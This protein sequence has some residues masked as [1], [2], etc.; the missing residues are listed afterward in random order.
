MKDRIYRSGAGRYINDLETGF[1]PNITIDYPCSQS[2]DSLVA[3]YESNTAA[4]VTARGGGI[5]PTTFSI[6]EQTVQP[7]VTAQVSN[8]DFE[9]G[10]LTGWTTWT[11]G[12][13]PGG[14][15]AFDENNGTAQ[16]GQWKGT[17]FTDTDVSQVKLYT[18]LRGLQPGV[19]YRVN[20]GASLPPD[21]GL[22]WEIVSR[23]VGHYGKVSEVHAGI[24]RGSGPDGHRNRS[25]YCG[26]RWRAGDQ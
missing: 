17:V 25:A 26:G 23:E 4:Q 2:W 3:L 5:T 1:P 9:H 8:Y 22:K 19:T 11:P 14:P 6:N 7:E 16:S 21:S 24:P 12:A 10:T 18:T 20:W 13:D 15:N